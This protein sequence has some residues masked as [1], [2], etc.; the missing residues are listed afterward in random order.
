MKSAVVLFWIHVFISN[1]R[2]QWDLSTLFE[3][4]QLLMHCAV[5]IWA[6]WESQE[7]V[8]CGYKHFLWYL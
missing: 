5:L 4:K 8:I 1:K 3:W 7:L 2:N 6:K